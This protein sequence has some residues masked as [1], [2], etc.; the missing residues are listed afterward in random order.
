AKRRAKELQTARP[1]S[2]EPPAEALWA[3]VRR[4][5][6]EEVAGLPEKFRAPFVLCHLQGKTNAQAAEEL[7]CPRGT[8]LSRLA[9]ARERLRARLERRGVTLSAAALSALLAQECAAT[10]LPRGMAVAAVRVALAAGSGAGA[11]ARQASGAV[12]ALAEGALRATPWMKVRA[13]ALA[14][15]L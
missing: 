3:D 5:L 10:V 12:E 1:A 7:G 6:D 4:V 13:A 11:A 8:V 14:L 15:L 2:C 9:T